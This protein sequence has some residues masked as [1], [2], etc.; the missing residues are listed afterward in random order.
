MDQ[1]RSA[2]QVGD[3][4]EDNRAGQRQPTPERERDH[5]GDHA[6]GERVERKQQ[7]EVDREGHQAGREPGLIGLGIGLA[8]TD[9]A[10]QCVVECLGQTRQL[11][12]D[13]GDQPGALGCDRGPYLRCLGDALDQHLHLAAREHLV[14]GLLGGLGLEH[15]LDDPGHLLAVEPGRLDVAGHRALDRPA[16]GGAAQSTHDR[17]LDR[18]VQ[19]PVHPRGV[20]HPACAS[21][22]GAQQAGNRR[23]VGVLVHGCA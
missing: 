5:R 2:E 12:A 23:L 19:G 3:Q 20:S 10:L 22:P 7:R 4:P 16:N 15:L 21:G 18:L 8:V 14:P 17:L 1:H 11:D 9:D 13:V 6:G